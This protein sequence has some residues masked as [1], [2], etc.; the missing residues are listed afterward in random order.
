[1]RFRSM[2]ITGATMAAS[3][4]LVAMASPALADG[5]KGPNQTARAT[6]RTSIRNAGAATNS[7]TVNKSNRSSNSTFV[8]QISQ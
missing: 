5:K 6:Q 8:T 7:L 1:M 3:L 4:A 2:L